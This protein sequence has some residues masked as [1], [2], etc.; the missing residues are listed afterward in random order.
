MAGESIKTVETEKT[1]FIQETIDNYFAVI[2]G[3]RIVFVFRFR[4]CKFGF[5]IPKA[6]T[7][8]FRFKSTKSQRPKV[9]QNSR[10]GIQ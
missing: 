3:T 8:K 10:V 2:I 4:N 1:A 9:D 5:K 6:Q 7:S